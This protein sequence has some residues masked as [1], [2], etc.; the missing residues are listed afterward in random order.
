MLDTTS[1]VYMVMDPKGRVKIGWTRDL[2]AR[3]G[4]LNASTADNFQLLR[5]ITGGKPTERWLHKKFAHLRI[6]GEWF[7]F[8]QAMLTIV[9]PDELPIRRGRGR[10]M[11]S[12]EAHLIIALHCGMEDV[13]LV[14]GMD[15]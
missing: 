3:V 5:V 15:I 10:V 14:L 4:A 13:R 1:V 12:A 8:D 11:S 6:K 9:T 2:D 7:Q